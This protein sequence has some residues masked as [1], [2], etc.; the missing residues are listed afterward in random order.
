VVEVSPKTRRDDLRERVD[1]L[2]ELVEIR[3]DSLEDASIDDIW[4]G[5]FPIGMIANNAN[6][7]SQDV[8]SSVWDLEDR[9][10][11]IEQ[12]LMVLEDAV[13]TDLEE[14]EYGQLSRKDKARAIQEELVE[15]AK[16]RPTNKAAMTY[17]EVYHLF[18]AKPSTGHV[19]DLMKLAAQEPGFDYDDLE[20]EKDR[21]TV[22]L[23]DVKE[24]LLVHVANNS[25]Q[26]EAV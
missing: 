8:E 22:D 9:L 2:E 11:E 13:N 18:N 12:R 5:G 17:N 16:D 7:R 10:D 14:K 23:A 3:A 21:I 15:T 4:I 25:P 26:E 24:S 19:Y 6:G 20:E 1:E